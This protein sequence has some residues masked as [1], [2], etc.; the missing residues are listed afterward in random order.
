MAE[1]LPTSVSAFS[2]RRHRAD[3]TTSFTYYDDEQEAQLN[4]DASHSFS[5]QSIV[6]EYT[7]RSLSDV[8]DLEFGAVVDAIEDDDEYDDSS[9]QDYQA[10][11]NDYVL[12]RSST[13]S[14]T[15]VHA[16]LLR[17]DSTTTA[18]SSYGGRTS[19]K[20]YMVNEDL[21]IAIAG[22][23]TSKT[24]YLVYL[25]LCIMTGGIAYLLFRWLPRWYVGILGQQCPLGECDWVVIENQWGEL[26]TVDV[27]VRLY[28]RPLSSVFGMPEK[29]FSDTLDEDSDPFLQDLRTIDY[30]YVRFCFHPLK[31]KF[32]L[33]SGWKDP[34]WTDVRLVRAGLDTDERTNREIVFGNNL[35]D[36]EQKSVGQLLIDEVSHPTHF[37]Q[38]YMS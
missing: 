11:Q 14:R 29:L 21:T 8:G 36:I 35:I 20:V 18:I 2:H 1:S 30:R 19:Q 24:G 7:R 17:R 26:V 22:F 3:S 28:G 38:F 16:Q 32:V 4:L 12:R 5:R 37:L 31:D 13:H 10:S 9:S 15:S 23:R 6:D 34:E 25:A 33:C 27:Q